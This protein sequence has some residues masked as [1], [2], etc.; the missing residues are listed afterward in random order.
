MVC[1][2]LPLE[3]ADSRFSCDSDSDSGR[4]PL[5]QA[6][7]SDMEDD[8]MS[9][10]PIARQLSSDGKQVR[11]SSQRSKGRG[12]NMGKFERAAAINSTAPAICLLSQ[13]T[14]SPGTLHTH[15]ERLFVS[16]EMHSG[17]AGAIGWRE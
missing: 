14:V 13:V 3:V 4:L 11:H 17:T 7:F 16:A 15:S 8:C 6:R 1:C 5:P 10:T 9:R 12:H 2:C